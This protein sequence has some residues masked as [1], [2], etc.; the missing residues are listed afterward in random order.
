MEPPFP[1]PIRAGGSLAT[2]TSRTLSALSVFH[3]LRARAKSFLSGKFTR[4]EVV[5]AGSEPEAAH[6]REPVAIFTGE[7]LPHYAA[8]IDDAP[9]GYRS[10]N[11]RWKSGVFSKRKK[12][13][14]H[15][16]IGYGR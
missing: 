9:F 11:L 7:V 1:P 5:Y 14:S 3:V 12:S 4:G 6:D 2:L 13:M 16:V 10:T 8:D 15:I